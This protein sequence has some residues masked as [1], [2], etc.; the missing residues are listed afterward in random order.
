M[1]WSF[2]SKPPGAFF[3]N[4]R[5]LTPDEFGAVIFMLVSQ[6]SIE[7]VKQLLGLGTESAGGDSLFGRMASAPRLVQ[8]QVVAMQLTW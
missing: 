1:G 7:D 2:F 4:G 8:Y 6:H 3:F 5:R